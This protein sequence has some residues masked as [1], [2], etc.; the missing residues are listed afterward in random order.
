M[1][2]PQYPVRRMTTTKN[3][4]C[5]C[6]FFHKVL[7]NTRRPI[8]KPLLWELIKKELHS[9]I[10]KHSVTKKDR[11]IKDIE[12]SLQTRLQDLEKNICNSNIL[13]TDISNSINFGA[14]F[15]NWFSLYSDTQSSVIN[16]GYTTEY[17]EVSK[18][19]RQAVLFA[20]FVLFLL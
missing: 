13:H 7:K 6:S 10:I 4:S 1:E 2:I 14:K 3:E 9:K 17:F 15:R 12:I 11:E 8:N 5:S 18:G 19:V 16:G 20:L